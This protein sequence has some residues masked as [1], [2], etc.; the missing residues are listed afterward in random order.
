MH[1]DGRMNTAMALPGALAACALFLAACSSTPD[2]PGTGGD[3]LH[4]NG[5]S[6]AGA[7]GGGDHGD[8]ARACHDAGSN[9]DAGPA[10][11]GASD[12]EPPAEYRACQIDDDCIA[13]ARA[14]CCH[15]GWKTAV[16][17][18]EVDAYDGAF[19]CHEERPICPLYI[20][21]DTR[22][23]ECDRATRLCG[24][25]AIEDIACGGFIA[26]AHRCPD[27]YVCR[28]SRIPDVPGHCVADGD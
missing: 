9:A 4:L 6:L 8:C 24:M 5:E 1:R 23:A 10:D 26:N 25:V 11:S 15:N 21:N 20:V 14:G 17:H 2:S 16:N 3:A 13:V 27:G 12:G 7:C 22:V 19:A 28:Y 18:S